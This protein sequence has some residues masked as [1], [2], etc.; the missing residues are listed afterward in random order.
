MENHTKECL[1][2]EYRNCT[3]PKI[4]EYAEAWNDYVNVMQDFFDYT[5]ESETSKDILKWWSSKIRQVEL[6]AY[7]K[8]QKEARTHY[9]DMV[10][11]KERKDIAKKI[12][13]I[14]NFTACELPDERFSKENYYHITELNFEELLNNL[15]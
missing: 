1:E 13:K 2:S 12:K 10:R 11:S 14:A 8:G 9:Y 3:C 4:P 6:K 15:K 5:S 7:Q